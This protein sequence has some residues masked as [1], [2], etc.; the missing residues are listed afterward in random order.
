[1]GDGTS[2]GARCPRD[3]QLHRKIEAYDDDTL[4]APEKTAE[5]QVA[6]TAYRK[7]EKQ[8]LQTSIRQ[9]QRRTDAIAASVRVM[10]TFDFRG[11]AAF[12]G[13]NDPR[14]R[15]WIGEMGLAPAA[16]RKSAAVLIVDKPSAP[17]N[18]VL[19]AAALGGGCIAC[20][21]HGS[22]IMYK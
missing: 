5:L 21:W 9:A 10:P 11:K 22:F 19:W 18:R 15:T 13:S 14:A 6:V 2:E 3:R 4:L 7:R 8:N 12:C 1:M 17:G 16:D 20:P